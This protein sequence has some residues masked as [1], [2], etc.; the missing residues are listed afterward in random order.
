[1]NEKHKEVS[2]VIAHDV[3]EVPPEGRRRLNPRVVGRVRRGTGALDG[4]LGLR[5]GYGWGPAF[6]QTDTCLVLSPVKSL[7]SQSPHRLTRRSPA[8]RAIRSSS[9]GHA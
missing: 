4:V 3:R 1:M 6:C 7:L 2:R 8:S 9:A 5:R